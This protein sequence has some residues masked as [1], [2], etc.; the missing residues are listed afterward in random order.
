MTKTPIQLVSLGAAK[1][2]TRA[3]VDGNFLELT[4]LPRQIP[5]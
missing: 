2:L 4:M 1:A 3:D 5:G